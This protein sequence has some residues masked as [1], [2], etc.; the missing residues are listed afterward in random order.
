MPAGSEYLFQLLPTLPKFW[1]ATASSPRAL[2]IMSKITPVRKK[3]GPVSL[4]TQAGL[5]PS[6][7]FIA[8]ITGPAWVECL[9]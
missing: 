2:L 8:Q 7:F 1:Q 5:K 3:M 9:H 6:A 4:Q